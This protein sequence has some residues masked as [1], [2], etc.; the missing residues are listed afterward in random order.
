MLRTG[1]FGQEKKKREIQKTTK[2]RKK[3]GPV[4]EFCL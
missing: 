2:K 1:L 4:S 3:K